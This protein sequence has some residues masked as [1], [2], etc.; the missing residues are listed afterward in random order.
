[1]RACVALVLALFA[2]GCG[3]VRACRAS[4]ILVSLAFPD[5]GAGADTLELDVAIDGTPSKVNM[6]PLAGQTAGTV[7]IDF[8]SGWPA[9]HV[10]MLRARATAQGSQV[11]VGQTTI[12][13]PDGC[14]TATIDLQ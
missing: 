2:A 10:V 9:G 12:T 4:S 5:A 14:A 7:E 1:M 8:P 13:L 3:G 6:F 11:A